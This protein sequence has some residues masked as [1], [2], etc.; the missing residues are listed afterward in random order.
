MLTDEVQVVPH[1]AVPSEPS[2]RTEGRTAVLRGITV[3][4]VAGVAHLLLQVLTRSEYPGDF[5][6]A[7]R[8]AYTLSNGIDPYGFTPDPTFVPYPL[9]VALFGLPF[10]WVVGV[11]PLYFPSGVFIGVSAGLLTWSMLRAGENWRLATILL[12][13]PFWVAVVISQWSPLVVAAWYIPVLAPL[14]V[15]I[16]PQIALP[17]AIARAPSRV[18]LLIAAVVLLVSLIIDPTWPWRFLEATGP[19]QSTIPVLTLPLGPLLVLAAIR[20]RDER[21]RLL[22][23][24]AI[25]PQRTV[26]D[27]LALWL[28]P[29]RLPV[30]VLLTVLSGLVVLAGLPTW[31]AMVQYPDMRWAIHLLYIPLLALVLWKKS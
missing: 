9:P 7:L 16:K 6:W 19:Y 26:Y 14:L 31:P 2:F 4:L 23:L 8:T 24:M 27:F 17:V 28:V 18:G 3:G 30:A 22:L 11:L 25:M 5:V 15:L 20:W 21:A 13:G 29:T 1:P 10:L 12:S